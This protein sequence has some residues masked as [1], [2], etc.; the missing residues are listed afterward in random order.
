[1]NVEA[2]NSGMEQQ[3]ARGP[4]KPEVAGSSPAP[5]PSNHLED[6]GCADCR[7]VVGWRG[8]FRIGRRVA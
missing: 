8:L 5:A 3:E 4:H 7:T 2:D 1:M 6:R